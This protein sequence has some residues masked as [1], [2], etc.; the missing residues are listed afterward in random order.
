MKVHQYIYT[1]ITQTESS[2][3]HSFMSHRFPSPYHTHKK[4]LLFPKFLSLQL[5]IKNHKLIKFQKLNIFTITFLNSYW[6]PT[7]LFRM[8]VW[9]D[10]LNNLSVYQPNSFYKVNIPCTKSH[11]SNLQIPYIHS[12]G[13]NFLKRKRTF[14]NEIRVI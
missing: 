7:I 2:L 12:S 14:P 6:D 5:Y 3:Y 1:N 8:A 4:K 13:S 11:C 10:N 9:R